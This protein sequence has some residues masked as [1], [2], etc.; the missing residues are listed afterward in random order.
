MTDSIK[1]YGNPICPFAHRA[2]WTSKE[3]QVPTEFIHIPLGS[4][5]PEWFTQTVNPR[6][7]VPAVQ[8]GSHTILESM[9]ITEFFEDQFPNQ[10][11][12]LLPKDAF[13]RADVRLF[14]DQFGQAITVMY[15]LLKNQ[16]RSKDE[17]LKAQI[18]AKLKVAVDLLKKQSD[19]PFF[20][21]EEL[22]LADI[23]ALPFIDRFS[24]TLAHYRNY[25]LFEVDDRLHTWYAAAKERKAFQETS[26][27]PAFYIDS[28][29]E[30]A[31]PK[32]QS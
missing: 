12:Q 29:K 25:N 17:E 9:I 15:G 7:T 21:G 4:E 3:K 27:D 1:F 31:V 23:A 24:A 10:G 18:T 32:Q 8:I 11:S 13:Q 2:W 6:G 30:Y 26:K 20:L 28:Y 5:K 14:I 22:S 19:G 16:D